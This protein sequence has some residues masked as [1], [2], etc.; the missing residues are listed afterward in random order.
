MRLHADLLKPAVHPE[1]VG[2]RVIAEYRY[3]ILA[4]GLERTGKTEQRSASYAASEKKRTVSVRVGGES[5][6]EAIE[7]VECVAWFHAAHEFRAL[8]HGVVEKGNLTA[9]MRPIAYRYG[10]AQEFLR[11]GDIDKLPRSLYG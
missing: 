10:S 11:Y 2:S 8:P 6:A 3:R 9:L 5:V 1:R 7:H 4:A